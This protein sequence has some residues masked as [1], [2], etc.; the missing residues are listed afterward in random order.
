MKFRFSVFFVSVLL[1]VS[2]LNLPASAAFVPDDVLFN[3][4][5]VAAWDSE[6]NIWFLK[7][8]PTD[9][10]ESGWLSWCWRQ[11][12][13]AVEVSGYG[14]VRDEV[15]LLRKATTFNSQ[16]RS[17]MDGS[18]GSNLLSMGYIP[19]AVVQYHAPI[20]CFVLVDKVSGIPIVDSDG[21]FAYYVPTKTDP[22]TNTEV[23]DPAL[24]GQWIRRDQVS[25]LMTNVVNEATLYDLGW[26]L[27]SE[28]QDNTV[29]SHAEKIQYIA[30]EWE[31]MGEHYV[32]C[33]SQGRPYVYRPALDQWAQDSNN[34]Y[35][36]DDKDGDGVY[37]SGETEN[38]TL[39]D[40]DTNTVWFPDG[41][42]NYIDNL[43][44][45]DSTKTY[46]VDAHTEYNVEN[47]TYV[48][49]NYK[50]EYHI[51]YTSVTYIGQT[52]EY[53]KLYEFYYELPDGRSSADLTAD[54]LQA[55]NT[56]VD[57]VPY[58]RSADSTA[59][60]S[61]YHFDGNTFDDSYW[62]YQTEFKWVDGASLTYMDAGPFNGALYL[63]EQKHEFT[64]S[65]PSGLGSKDFTIQW[66][67]YQSQTLDT[68]GIDDSY[69]KL[70]GINVLY[71]D[72]K[73]YTLGSTSYPT[74]IGS[75]HEV[76][77]IRHNGK[78]RLYVNGLPVATQ[79]NSTAYG[80]DI[81]FRFGAVQQTYK[82]FDELRVLDYAIAEN[83]T[84][85]TPTSVPHDTNL[86]L[87]LPDATVPV[88]DEY[89]S[90]NASGN[91]LPVYDLTQLPG[92]DSFAW[93]TAGQDDIDPHASEDLIWEVNVTSG[94]IGVFAA[95]GYYT[96]QNYGDVV[97]IYSNWSSSSD[98]MKMYLGYHLSSG[99]NE[100]FAPGMEPGDT[101]TFSVVLKDGTVHSMP[102][103]LP[104]RYSSGFK[105]ISSIDIDGGLLAVTF[106]G[107]EYWLWFCPPAWDSMDIIYWELK[108]GAANTG[109]EWVSAVAPVADDFRTPTLAVRT[110][111]TIT[112]YQI[113]GVRPSLPS[114]GLV[115]ALVEAGRISSL[116]IY[117]GQ[118]WEAVDGR[119]WT[120][121]RW[122]PYYA[123]NVVLLKDMYDVI[124]ADPELEYIYTEQGFWSWLQ[125]AWGKLMDKLDQILHAIGSGGGGGGQTSDCQHVYRSE[126]GREATC[127]E[128]GTRLY[129]CDLCG[130]QYAEL[131]DAIGHDWIVTNSV[132]DVLDSDG[133]VI[134]AGYDELTCSVCDAKSKDYGDGPQEQDIFD[135]VGDFISDG[136]TWVLDKLT[137]LADSLHG[138]TDVFNSFVERLQGMGGAFPAFFGAFI[139]LIPEDLAVIL[140]FSVVAFVVIA[141]WKKWTE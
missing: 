90:F 107:G 20:G 81:T 88:A 59:L 61:L 68:S 4:D 131:I 10:A 112:G 62:S 86:T 48:T 47:N 57:V 43:I 15:T 110:S 36:T 135:A 77:L 22:E 89:W 27:R 123:Y 2:L 106:R 52:A 141:V 133:R 26:A 40:L 39:I 118:A 66:R 98:A 115:W 132:P 108:E 111:H 37:D 93:D 6:F 13:K 127:A 41:T 42:V 119:I 130:H 100:F 8:L 83:G 122:V 38:N 29:R 136:I 58:I 84:S 63:D 69:V 72:G 31:T 54:E 128:P 78:L 114:K 80:K 14:R 124:G 30:S 50:Y 56:Q 33:D 55:L 139:A 1:G 102:F 82:Y 25:W 9:F 12:D 99:A 75:W 116:Q 49:N 125:G 23:N 44:Y 129:M 24:G 101:W 85:Y 79:S 16:V 103:T 138:I 67:F 91:V 21:R 64:V 96:F 35:Y 7:L 18:W 92:F 46:F 19:T 95:D 70:G 113:G 120:G 87:V 60:R 76:A 32:Y 51:N 117:N 140:W 5:A 109:H 121:S 45:D 73:T 134:E 105:V 97:D 53:D 3:H 28:G 74:P 65:L 17:F 126:I 34:N 104:A 94:N 11:M 137:E 71:M